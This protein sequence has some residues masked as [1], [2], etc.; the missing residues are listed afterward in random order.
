M[1]G[2]SAMVRLVYDTNDTE[3]SGIFLLEFDYIFKFQ[4]EIEIKG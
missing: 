4:K 2:M 1:Q 3:Y